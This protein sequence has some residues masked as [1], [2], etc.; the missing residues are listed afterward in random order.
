MD[1]VAEKVAK[2]QLNIEAVRRMY[3]EGTLFP[4]KPVSTD[5]TALLEETT[6]ATIARANG[7]RM[8]EA[9]SNG[10]KGFNKIIIGDVH[11]RE[12]DP[13]FLMYHPNITKIIEAMIK[14]GIITPRDRVCSESA[15]GE[16]DF[17][18]DKS[19]TVPLDERHFIRRAFDVL[20]DSGLVVVYND[21]AELGREYDRKR[22]ENRTEQTPQTNLEEIAAFVR[23][24]EGFGKSLESIE[25]RA[26]QV[27]GM[28][29]LFT[30]IVQERLR[31]RKESYIAIIPEEGARS[32]LDIEKA[33]PF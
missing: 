18:N 23:R 4:E 3:R 15:E 16:I 29:D 11:Y 28:W 8:F 33:K 27:F 19:Y 17:S 13:E 2:Y 30:G 26:V 21:S 14:G 9:Y 22:A 31:G 10:H 6:I 7:F 24:V 20:K 1:D 12:A 5:P 25:G 32:V